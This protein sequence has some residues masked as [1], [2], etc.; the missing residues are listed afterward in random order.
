MGVM[1]EHQ[2]T[3][4]FVLI[5]T[6]LGATAEVA[7]QVSEVNGVHWAIVVTGPYDIIAGV[8]VSDNM[9]L[10]TL[11]MEEIQAIPGVRNPLTVVVTRYYEDG[12]SRAPHGGFP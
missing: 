7:A 1:E 11:V 6:E 8:R 2:D 12:E 9:A 5:K 10:G 4:A 3:I